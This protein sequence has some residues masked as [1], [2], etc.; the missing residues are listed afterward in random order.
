VQLEV[1]FARPQGRTQKTCHDQLKA[2]YKS[3]LANDVIKIIQENEQNTVRTIL[4]SSLTVL[5]FG[6]SE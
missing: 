1:D 6:V 2:K 5:K 3:F 4:R